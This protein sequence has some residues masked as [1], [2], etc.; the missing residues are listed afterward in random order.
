MRATAIATILAVGM[1]IGHAE[2]QYV[3]I[4]KTFLPSLDAA[5]RR[6]RVRNP[7]P[8]SAPDVKTTL[9]RMADA[10]GMLRGTDERDAILTMEWRGTGTM[11]VGG[12]SCRLAH[13]RGSVRYNVPALRTEFA[14]AQADGTPGPRTSQVVAGVLA[15]NETAPGVGATPA[16][17]TATDRLAQLWSLPFSVYKAAAAAGTGTKV[18]LEGGIVYV[19]YPLPAPLNGTA[20]A[21][22]N[23]TDAIELTMDSGEKYQL[24]YWIDRVEE[25]IGNVVTETTYSDYSELNEPDYRSDV[26]FP[27]HIVQKRGGVTLLDLV[28]ERT[29]TYNPYVVMPVQAVSVPATAAQRG[30]GAAPA[31]SAPLATP[32]TA[33]GKPDLSGRWGGGGGGGGST[34]VQG[35]DKDGTRV[36]Y[37]TLEEAKAKATKIFARN[38]NARH[39]NPTYAERDQGMTDRYRDHLDPPIYKPEHWDRVQYLDLHGNYLDSSFLCAPVGLPR[40]GA[41]VRIVQAAGEVVLMYNARNTWRVVPTDGRPHSPADDRDQTYMGDS[42]GRWD[43]DTLV[44]EAVGFNDDT[45]IGWPGWFHSTEMRVVE[46]FRREGNTL[47]YGFTVYDP[48]LAEPWDVKPR[49]IPLNT[50]KAPYNED[51]PCIMNPRPMVSRERG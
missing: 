16:P 36:T 13:Y 51:P 43:G 19:T 49:A 26:L 5:V 3:G 45:W 28:V 7:P 6:V 39:A 30:G 12:Q 17:D 14:C 22:L 48:V 47:Y 23:T 37:A 9:Y 34:E 35:L 41:P 10:L 31:A 4:P 25:R 2:A 33:D 24:S 44:I 42:V 29:N 38:Y 50:S 27:R 15:W 1:T 32:R 40:I 11:T 20:R 8:T 46:R 21:A 18:T